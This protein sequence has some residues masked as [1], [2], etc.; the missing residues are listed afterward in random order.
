MYHGQEK[1]A[2]RV[3]E[4]KSSGKPFRSSNQS[5]QYHSLEDEAD[6]VSSRALSGTTNMGAALHNLSK[7]TG[8]DMSKVPVVQRPIGETGFTEGGTV[9]LDSSVNLSEPSG[10][11]VL[12]H[13]M[14][15]AA[16]QSA[17]RVSGSQVSAAP[18]GMVQ[19]FP[20]EIK[21]EY[22]KDRAYLD[23]AN[24]AST[25]DL[26]IDKASHPDV[27]EGIGGQDKKRKKLQNAAM[28]YVRA[29]SEKKG[30]LGG[31][32]HK[33]RLQ[34][35]NSLLSALTAFNQRL[36]SERR[37]KGEE[38]A[39]TVVRNSKNPMGAPTA[40]QAQKRVD[41][42]RV[43]PKKAYK[44]A[45]SM[46]AVGKDFENINLSEIEVAADL[47][48]ATMDASPSGKMRMSEVYSGKAKDENNYPLALLDKGRN[49][50]G[51]Y[52]HTSDMLAGK[53]ADRVSTGHFDHRKKGAYVPWNA[54][55]ETYTPAHEMGHLAT[56]DIE[57]KMFS[58]QNA[59]DA[60][61]AKKAFAKSR[62]TRG[63]A[64]A[65]MFDAA[66]EALSDDSFRDDVVAHLKFDD[67][68]VKDTIQLYFAHDP[69]VLE[70]VDFQKAF[71]LQMCPKFLLE[72]GY[73]TQY[74]ATNPDEVIAEAF[75]DYYRDQ[76]KI[77]K[78]EKY[79]ADKQNPG[80]RVKYGA[81]RN[82]FSKAV[83]ELMKSLH[84]DKEIDG[85]TG[86]ERRAAFFDR[87]KD[88]FNERK[89]KLETTNFTNAY[90]TVWL[91]VCGETNQKNVEKQAKDVYDGALADANR[92]YQKQ[93][94]KM[95][96]DEIKI[97]SEKF[98]RDQEQELRQ[99]YAT[100][101]AREAKFEDAKRVPNQPQ[102]GPTGQPGG[103]G[104]WKPVMPS[105]EALAKKL[106]EMRGK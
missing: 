36:D 101:Y 38:M 77:Q 29:T 104:Q 63:T 81:T 22:K 3:A 65:I 72:I 86:A 7:A 71:Q 27:V 14:V 41:F 16:Q 73:T 9:H 59:S 43:D 98:A 49:N 97:K 89:K 44:Y 53:Q 8:A 78:Q 39:Q 60:D 69:D 46:N 50:Q 40:N 30:L 74:G 99:L 76:N 4:S 12:G 34:Q 24:M 5:S 23:L 31:Q 66:R 88:D 92:H 13:E 85:K 94:P 91:D 90:A 82:P 33:G 58:E 83:V 80:R 32:K 25:E 47:G 95:T 48:S 56:Y 106:A 102:N 52:M 61:A 15:H 57:K 1:K 84:S 55:N 67:P 64:D 62:N 19:H 2:N 75:K 96:D 6:S 28:E 37:S 10:M 70:N 54:A 17:G 51:N 35:V 42:S 18:A 45:K 68:D 26:D 87:H 103:Q 93:V 21:K 100:P 79:D 11:Q 20:M 105:K